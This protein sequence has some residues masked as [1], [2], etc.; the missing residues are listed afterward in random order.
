MSVEDQIQ[1]LREVVEG[2]VKEDERFIMILGN[3]NQ[4]IGRLEDETSARA[5]RSH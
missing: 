2:M 3:L 1:L 4:R 5:N